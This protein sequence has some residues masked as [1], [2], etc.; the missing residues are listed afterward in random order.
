MSVN[1]KIVIKLT[2]EQRKE[3]QEQ[4]GKEVTHI[5]LQLVAGIVIL[6]E[7]SEARV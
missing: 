6:A 1:K 2:D 3:V 7:A 5:T 4:L